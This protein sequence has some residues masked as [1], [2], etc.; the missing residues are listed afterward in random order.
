MNDLR[1]AILAAVSHDLRTPLASVKAA[2]SSLRQRDV[3]WNAAEV[4]EFLATIEE[5]TD[6]LSSLVGNLLDASRIQTGAS[7]WCAIGW[8]STRWCRRRSRACPTGAATSTSTCRRSLPR[9]DVDAAL[10]ERAIANIAANARVARL[11]ARA[12][13]ASSGSEAGGRVELRIVDRGPGIPL[14]E[15]QR[16][17]EP[18][19]RL[20]D[21]SSSDGVGLG[22]AVARGFV[23]A[24][25]GE[26]EVEDTPG[27]GLTMVLAFKAES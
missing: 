1:A 15:R 26:V 27:G 3:H 25:G 13:S 14:E 21:H 4:D 5:E 19:Q 8:A 11:V 17:F 6:R 18:F 20:G 10:L 2:V 22:L 12:R 9:V 23:E 7:G 24:M 16:V